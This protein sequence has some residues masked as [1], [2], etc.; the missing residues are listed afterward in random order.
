MEIKK[1]SNQ[2]VDNINLLIYGESGVGKT[3]LIKTLP[4]PFIINVEG[5][6]LS[7][8]DVELDHT[9]AKSFNELWEDCN[10]IKK[11]L[12]NGKFPYKSLVLDSISEMAEMVLA[13]EKRIN[14]D[15]RQAYGNTNDKMSAII[16]RFRDLPITVYFIAKS[17]KVQDENVLV[18]QP[19]MPGQ[20]LT[21][22]LAYMFD[23][24]YAMVINKEEDGSISRWLLTENNGKYVAKSRL[25]VLNTWE[26]PNLNNILNKAYSTNKGVNSNEHK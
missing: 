1:T 2:L 13:E 6:L 15:G 24:V 7:I 12:D 22:D 11:A 10:S 4:K 19:S 5:G 18:Y 21:K 16:R 23:E 17:E 8:R 3:S 26:E 9:D 14:K 20:K 25:G